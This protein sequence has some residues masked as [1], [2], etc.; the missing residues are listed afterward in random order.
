MRLR[1]RKLGGW[2]IDMSGRLVLRYC[3]V[4]AI[5]RVCMHMR[6]YASGAR[7]RTSALGPASL[8]LILR[9]SV[10]QSP[11]NRKGH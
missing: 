2:Q 4:A 8:G 3:I 1:G 10:L 6:A 5:I 9:T 11:M 7:H